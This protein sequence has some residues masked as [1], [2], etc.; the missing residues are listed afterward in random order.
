MHHTRGE[1]A[2][3]TCKHEAVSK[4]VL[5]AFDVAKETG[6]RFSR[7][8]PH[9]PICVVDA[10]RPLPPLLG[11]L[12]VLSVRTSHHRVPTVPL[13]GNGDGDH[14]A[15]VRVVATALVVFR[16][17]ARGGLHICVGGALRIRAQ[18]SGHLRASLVQ[19]G[20]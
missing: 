8:S 20:C 2:L 12:R 1:R 6:D 14:A 19:P 10:A 11:L 16:A 15:V 4:R 17:G 9:E 13:P 5:D 18:R 3:M 7:P